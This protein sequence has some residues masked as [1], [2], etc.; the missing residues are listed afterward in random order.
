MPHTHSTVISRLGYEN[1]AG[2]Q[3]SALQS[4]HV[5]EA[6]KLASPFP[7]S[8]EVC[9]WH[10]RLRRVGGRIYQHAARNF[11]GQQRP[12]VCKAHM[13]L[14][15]LR[16]SSVPFPDDMLITDDGG[17]WYAS[18]IPISTWAAAARLSTSTVPAKCQASVAAKSTWS[19]KSAD[20]AT[21]FDA[22]NA[23]VSTT[24]APTTK[25]GSECIK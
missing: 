6:R 25:T 2:I 20:A 17:I 23:S 12:A 1:P 16:D 21:C 5:Q 15:W 4:R 10:L 19:T 13:K 18:S 22:P 14:L 24:A 8:G 9:G 3:L 7:C 11:K